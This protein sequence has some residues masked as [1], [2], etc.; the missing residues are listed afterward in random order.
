[1]RLKAPLNLYFKNFWIFVPLV[2]YTYT[3]HSLYFVS[4]YRMIFSGGETK[5]RKGVFRSNKKRD[6]FR[7]L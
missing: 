1:M 7:Y 3:V 4:D 2:Y 5:K 6:L